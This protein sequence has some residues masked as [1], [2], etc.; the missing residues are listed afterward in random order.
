MKR[1]SKFSPQPRDL[2]AAV[3]RQR[4]SDPLA[5]SILPNLAAKVNENSL[6]SRQTASAAAGVAFLPCPML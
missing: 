4:L 6:P 2:K 3:R 1:H 5:V